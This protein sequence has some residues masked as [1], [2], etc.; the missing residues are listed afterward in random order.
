MQEVTF[1][2]RTFTLKLPIMLTV[3]AK[4]TGLGSKYLLSISRA[5]FSYK[6]LG[7]SDTEIRSGVSPHLSVQSLYPMC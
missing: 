1:T 3:L 2:S 5:P 6:L 4:Y 7:N